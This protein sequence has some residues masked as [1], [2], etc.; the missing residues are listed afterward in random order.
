MH[1]K[2]CAL[3]NQRMTL[4]RKPC[5]R[6]YSPHRRIGSIFPHRHNFLKYWSMWFKFRSSFFLF[7]FSGGNPWTALPL[8]TNFWQFWMT[9]FLSNC[10]LTIT[11]N[12]FLQ[13]M[14]KQ[15]CLR[16]SGYSVQADEEQLRYKAKLLLHAWLIIY[17]WHVNNCIWRKVCNTPALLGLSQGATWMPA[18]WT[19]RTVPV[20]GNGKKI[21]GNCLLA[22]LRLFCVKRC[23]IKHS[24]WITV[25]TTLFSI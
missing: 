8:G 5:K 20:Q 10:A 1:S 2:R 11:V 19:K 23:F 4:K 21:H 6:L 13:L 14:I 7:S 12:C 15:E 22:P 17:V 18:S 24:T 16:K 9:L 25:I 3:Q